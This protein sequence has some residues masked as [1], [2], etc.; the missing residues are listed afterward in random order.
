MIIDYYEAEIL[1]RFLLVFSRREK[2]IKELLLR[3]VRLRV[4]SPASLVGSQTS[5]DSEEPAAADVDTDYIQRERFIL[6]EL[7]IPARWL[8]QAKVCYFIEA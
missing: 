2:S 6:E 8:H 7:N 1:I 5:L 3:H 4:A